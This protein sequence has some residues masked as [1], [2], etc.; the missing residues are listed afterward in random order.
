M[1]EE[2][3]ETRVVVITGAAGAIA[4]TVAERFAAAGWRLA[5]LD[6]DKNLPRL[7]E[8]FPEAVGRGVDLRHP[9][10]TRDAVVRIEE[11]LGRIDA[12]LNIAGGFAMQSAA[13]AT[14]DDLEGQLSLNVHT[15]FNATTAALP[16]MLRRGS[17][18]VLG[19]AAAA[20]VAGAARMPAYGAAKS[21]VVGYLRAVRAEVEAKGVGISILYPMGAV[22]TPGN[23]H[24]MPGG[25]PTRWIS[26]D[27][28]AEAVLF[29]ANREAGGRV[30]ELQIYP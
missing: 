27:A 25:D 29:L 30:P 6:L 17:G 11:Q 12:L 20:A 2:K 1:A 9:E 14:S 7:A 16:G 10:A 15:L 26:R 4:G 8:R 22:D 18:F 28:L 19:V 24:A 3:A 21:A 23:R 13:E 5:L